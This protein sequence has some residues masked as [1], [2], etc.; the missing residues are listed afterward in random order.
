MG[1]LRM[2]CDLS[3][4]ESLPLL[5]I[6]QAVH[7]HAQNCTPPPTRTHFPLPRHPPPHTHC[8][9]MPSTRAG[10]TKDMAVAMVCTTRCPA[11]L[12]TFN[13]FELHSFG[14]Q[15]DRLVA[16]AQAL[17]KSSALSGSRFSDRNLCGLR[18]PEAEG[19]RGDQARGQRCVRPSTSPQAG[20]SAARARWGP[21]VFCTGLSGADRTFHAPQSKRKLVVTG[22]VVRQRMAVDHQQTPI[23]R[24]PSANYKFGSLFGPKIFWWRLRCL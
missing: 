17:S 11:S 13:Q 23:D 5:C 2:W 7:S 1:G 6:G 14:Q 20:T 18:L 12:C 21:G 9:K 4:L 19:G 15:R 8:P 10:H 16:F 3:G 22:H 24:R